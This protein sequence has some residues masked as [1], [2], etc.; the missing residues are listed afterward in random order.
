MQNNMILPGLPT[1]IAQYEIAKT[2]PNKSQRPYFNMY[3]SNDLHNICVLDKAV[4]EF[5]ADKSFF[6]GKTEKDTETVLSSKHSSFA[7][8]PAV[9][10]NYIEAERLLW[11]GDLGI[12]KIKEMR[13]TLEAYSYEMRSN[14]EQ[15]GSLEK[16]IDPTLKQK[17]MDE[18]NQTVEWLY[19]D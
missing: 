3:I 14:I 11:A 2:G 12:L 10:K 18:I 7:L 13:N 1:S 16:Y 9:R 17:F 6:G 15:Y 8:A 19:S 4:V 5:K